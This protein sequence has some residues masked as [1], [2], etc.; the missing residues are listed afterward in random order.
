LR[1]KMR[2][3]VIVMSRTLAAVVSQAVRIAAARVHPNVTL[4]AEVIP[5]P[6]FGPAHLRVAML[7][8]I[9]GRTRRLNERGIHDAASAHNIATLFG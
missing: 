7:L 8:F 5:V 4:H 9:L 6:L 1:Q 2:R 3:E